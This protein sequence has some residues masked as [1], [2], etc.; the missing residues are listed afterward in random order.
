MGRS[1]DPSIEEEIPGLLS[2]DGTWV[3]RRLFF[4]ADLYE[5]EKHRVFARS[6]LMVGHES[7]I[8]NPGDFF[9]SSMGEESVLVVRDNEGKVRVHLNSCPHRGMP[10]CREDRGNT[11]T[12]YC[13]YHGWSF[14]RDGALAGLPNQRASYP[15][16]FDKSNLGLIAVPRVETYCGLIFAN[17]D[18]GAVSLD[19]YLGDARWYLDTSLNRR[20]GG[21]EV[22][23]VQKWRIGTNWKVPAENM[24]GDVAHASASHASIFQIAP[25]DPTFD[26]ALKSV[27]EY[28]RNVA[29]PGGHGGT[30]RVYP[31]DDT[32]GR[33]PGEHVIREAPGVGE[34]LASV[35]AEA[36]ERLGE[37]RKHVKIATCTTFPNLF[38][39]G[40]NFTFRVA[41]PRGPMKSEL[42]SWVFVDREAPQEVKDAMRKFYTMTFGPGGMFEQ[43]DGENW[44]GVTYGASGI[45]ASAHPFH[46]GA[47]L[48][49]GAHPEL[50]GRVSTVYSEHTQRNLYLRWQE[51]MLQ[52]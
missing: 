10:V 6:W 52:P 7:Q 41:H 5:I 46:Y 9:L 15:K 36:E 20:A 21:I 4:D 43:D 31:K 37:V 16:D 39:L 44:E 3:S 12:F 34:Y 13:V 48:D 47:G 27:L 33:M 50:P 29:L 1:V 32:E 38:L 17:H 49:A 45:E 24:V 26:L 51:L 18:A 14:G 40:S 42:W 11:R 22:L 28:G 2:E 30:Y 25:G 23:G 35:Q 19:D 8:P